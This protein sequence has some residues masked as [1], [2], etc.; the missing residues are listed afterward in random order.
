MGGWGGVENRAW[1]PSRAGAGA[2]SP[3]APPGSAAPRS[4]EHVDA[5]TAL[6]E[7]LARRGASV[8]YAV[9]DVSGPPHQRWF[10]SL[11]LVGGRELGRGSARS[12]KGSEQLAA[13]Q[14]PGSLGPPVAAD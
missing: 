9:A 3:R 5:K 10:T 14:A 6:E 1:R 12:K 11:A 4:A 7:E 2:P 8:T 13:R